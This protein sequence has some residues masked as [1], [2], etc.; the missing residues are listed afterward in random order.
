MAKIPQYQQSRLAQLAV[1]VPQMDNSGQ[2]IAQNTI[3]NTGAIAGTLEN[4]ELHTIQAQQTQLKQSFSDLGFAG[5]VLEARQNAI[6]D[7]HQKLLDNIQAN[8]IKDQYSLELANRKNDLLSDKTIDPSKLPDEWKKI[9][10]QLPQTFHTMYPNVSSNAWDKATIGMNDLNTQNF[11]SIM[12]ASRN[13]GDQKAISDWETVQKQKVNAIQGPQGY[14]NALSELGTSDGQEAWKSV[15]GPHTS[16]KMEEFKQDAAN[17]L[18]TLTSAQGTPAL[19]NLKKSQILQDVSAAKWESAESAARNKTQAL[20]NIAV[21]Y[22]KIDEV[23]KAMGTSD[24]HTANPN[25]PNYMNVL[26]LAYEQ[27]KALAQ[28]QL[29]LPVY[30]K[31]K[32]VIDDQGRAI[33]YRSKQVYDSAINEQDTIKIRMKAFEESSLAQTEESLKGQTQPVVSRYEQAIVEQNQ[34]NSSPEA[35]QAT[36]QLRAQIA[37]LDSDFKGNTLNADAQGNQLKVH[38]VVD[39]Y[40]ATINSFA[41]ARK[42]GYIT[43]TE[44]ATMQKLFQLTSDRLKGPAAQQNLMQQANAFFTGKNLPTQDSINLEKSL[45]MALN[46]PI[47]V[48]NYI[49]NSVTGNSEAFKR[50]VSGQ[51]LLTRDAYLQ[52]FGHEPDV[53]EIR[54]NI[55]KV[56]KILLERDLTLSKQKQNVKKILPVN[57]NSKTVLVKPPPAVASTQN[58]FTNLDVNA[59]STM[60]LKDPAIGV[61][62]KARGVKLVPI[63]E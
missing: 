52:K 45:H 43:D 48:S 4:A 36:A 30:E 28:L 6:A 41:N 61:A 19:E 18:L 15:Y 39:Q 34:R 5:A 56:T 38:T 60:D 54:T 29:N 50:E 59:I 47:N 58:V 22:L 51:V 27:N 31:G 49:L 46:P 13:L 26:S 33:N 57:S 32:P 2:M 16:T 9:T 55:D 24:W 40:V 8:T 12:T 21:N 20:T 11:E 44:A 1:G 62:L 17:Q 63:N 37:L 14:I 25:D 23:N 53:G 7:A 10:T 35:Q 42:A 3:Q